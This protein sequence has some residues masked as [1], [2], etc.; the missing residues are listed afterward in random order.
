MGVI[1][2]KISFIGAG[3]AGFSLG[4][5]FKEKGLDVCGYYSRNLSSSKE[6]SVFTKTKHFERIE[7]LITESS[8]IFITVPDDEIL[9]VYSKLKCY[10]LKDKIICHTSGCLSSHIF[11]DI[12]DLGA[13]S[14]SFHPM[15]PISQKKE[16]YKYL[17]DAFFTIEGH[18][19]FLNYMTNLFSSIGIKIIQIESKDKSLYHL[20]SVTVSN[21]FL[22]LLNRSCNYL[23]NY[24]FSENEALNAL[25]PLI[26][27]NIENAVKFGITN[28]L[29][30]PIE[31]GDITTIQKHILSMPNEHEI[32][33][34]ELSKEL[35]SIARE[36]NK[37]KCYFNIE[38][39]LGNY[40]IK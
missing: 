32:V 31:R 14:Y 16:S 21:L 10:S 7:D 36:K 2:I 1:F 9:N 12:D 17:E 23:K 39:F 19:K 33:Y 22:A 8:I 20:A 24:G 3:K 29:T 38:N 25:Y 37:N 26:K 13:Y 35:I 4:K 28:A 18:S 34:S 15:F 11:S 40:Q 6:A 5:F 27:N 30:G